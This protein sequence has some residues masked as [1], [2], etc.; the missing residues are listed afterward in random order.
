MLQLM[1]A[2]IVFADPNNPD[3]GI[4]VLVK[5][6]FDV[7]VLDRTPGPTNGLE[8]FLSGPG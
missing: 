5:H 6:G 4:A 7:E 8:R 1:E 3:P 2:D